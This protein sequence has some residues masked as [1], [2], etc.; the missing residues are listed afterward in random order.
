MRVSW[1][2]RPESTNLVIGGEVAHVS[3]MEPIGRAIEFELKGNAIY[4][5]VACRR[6]GSPVVIAILEHG[7]RRP[8]PLLGTCF[9]IAC[10][11]AACQAEHSYTQAEIYEFRWPGRK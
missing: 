7:L 4:L 1:P 8:T 11:D 5:G 2:D 3:A 9:R 6:C 10:G